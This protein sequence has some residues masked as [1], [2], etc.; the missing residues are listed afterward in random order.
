MLADTDAAFAFETEVV[1][2]GS[3]F[4]VRVFDADHSSIGADLCTVLGST[5]G[6]SVGE[7]GK[8]NMGIVG[9]SSRGIM[10]FGLGFGEHKG[11]MSRPP[12]RSLVAM[13]CKDVSE[14]E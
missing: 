3:S 13:A 7:R 10:I 9:R 11:L 1:R 8:S 5:K 6:G 14:V 4:A 12:V 2:D